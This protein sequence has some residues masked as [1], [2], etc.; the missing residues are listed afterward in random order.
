MAKTGT[1]TITLESARPIDEWVAI[2]NIIIQALYE[3]G[4]RGSID[5]NV[6]LDT[7]SIRDLTNEDNEDEY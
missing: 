5:N 2:S 4:Y 1:I 7:E 3:Q 6:T